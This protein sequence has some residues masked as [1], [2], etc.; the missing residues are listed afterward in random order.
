MSIN[1]KDDYDKLARILYPSIEASGNVYYGQARKLTMD[2]I[3]GKNE[4]NFE[5]HIESIRVNN[6]MKDYGFDY[7]SYFLWK[8]GPLHDSIRFNTLQNNDIY[9][10]ENFPEVDKVALINEY[11]DEDN[12][13]YLHS[14]GS[15]TDYIGVTTTIPAGSYTN[16]LYGTVFAKY[17]LHFNNN[18]QIERIYSSDYKTYNS[19]IYC[20]FED[21]CLTN[22][23]NPT[24]VCDKN[25]G[26]RHFYIDNING[27]YYLYIQICTSNSNNYYYDADL[28][29]V[30]NDG[31]RHEIKWDENFREPL[32]I[33]AVDDSI[34]V[35]LK[36]NSLSPNAHYDYK[37][38]NDWVNYTLGDTINLNAGEYVKFRGDSY[39]GNTS[40]YAQFAI[41]GSGKA[42]ISG[43]IR[44][45]CYLHNKSE[46]GAFTNF[47]RLFYTSDSYNQNIISSP[48][49]PHTKSNSNFYRQLFANCGHL[50]K[51]PI[52]LVSQ[53]YQNDCMQ[54]FDNCESLTN[55]KPINAFTLGLDSFYSTFNSCI[56]LNNLEFYYYNS[57]EDISSYFD[58]WLDNINTIGTFTTN[59]SYLET[60]IPNT[61]TYKK[62]PFINNKKFIYASNISNIY[63]D[64]GSFEYSKDNFVVSGSNSINNGRGDITSRSTIYNMLSKAPDVSFD[65]YNKDGSFNQEIWGYKCF[66]SP[67]SFRNGIYGECAS[68]ITASDTEANTTF[69][70]EFICKKDESNITGDPCTLYKTYYRTIYNDPAEASSGNKLV[71]SISSM[72]SYADYNNAK[73]F[74]N[75]TKWHR[76]IKGTYQSNVLTKPGL[77]TIEYNSPFAVVNCANVCVDS[78]LVKTNTYDHEYHVAS[79]GTGYNNNTQ[80]STA[81]ATFT[82]YDVTS[83][84]YIGTS[85]TYNNIVKSS[86]IKL[87]NDPVGSENKTV[88]SNCNEK[89]VD[90]LVDLENSHYAEITLSST[91]SASNID[92]SADTVNINGDVTIN[93]NNILPSE[94][95][96]T[97]IGSPNKKIKNIFAKNINGVLP[98]V[99][100]LDDYAVDVPVGTIGLFAFSNR[101]RNDNYTNYTE[102]SYKYINTPLT[103]KA[104]E[105]STVRLVKGDAISSGNFSYK[106]KKNNSSEYSYSGETIDLSVGDTLSF[107]NYGAYGFLTSHSDTATDHTRFEI[108]GKVDVYG[109]IHSMLWHTYENLTDLT[110]LPFDD[111]VD[112][113]AFL[114]WQC[115]INDASNLVFPATK[116]PSYVYYSMFKEST[117]VCGPIPGKVTSSHSHAYMFKQ[118]T[119]LS[120]INRLPATAASDNCYFEMFSGCTSLIVSPEILLTT[121]ESYCCVSMFFGCSSLKIGPDLYANVLRNFCFNSM[122]KNCTSLEYVKCFATQ[123]NDTYDS[124]DWLSGASNVYVLYN[125]DVT[126]GDAVWNALNLSS[127]NSTHRVPVGDC[128]NDGSGGI[129]LFSI[130]PGEHLN[131]GLYINSNGTQVES[132][133]SN[134]D[135]EKL[136]K[137]SNIYI[138]GIA[139]IG[140]NIDA[141]ITIN[142]S[143][144][145]ADTY[146]KFVD[147]CIFKLLS[148]AVSKENNSLIALAMRVE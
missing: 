109:N 55:I 142:N 136:N 76:S 22:R 31:K 139:H 124:S 5:S 27:E 138:P 19:D 85:C 6:P 13:Y 135:Y 36:S 148:G 44:S 117:V 43:D 60:N 146:I 34:S 122:F 28:D 24:D 96:Y 73:T 65:D 23:A 141:N 132:D 133:L 3:L 92:I 147:S 108:T 51:P 46:S 84:A 21:L 94:D 121:L 86:S 38:N 91:S 105:P 8:L 68:L 70:S 7:N 119:S 88:L 99:N 9:T 128:F 98:C 144:D 71:S 69:A 113:F 17:K 100:K 15:L 81:E 57:D 93:A 89:I 143:Y 49:L 87:A 47:Y 80:I 14:D 62:V 116:V 78:S 140:T 83:K 106:Y 16:K 33:T 75:S 102:E 111:K 20:T 12:F 61:W 42:D 50:V 125:K 123:F 52:I 29:S 25:I 126:S 72:T 107:F 56:N 35:K 95:D 77:R 129:S 131:C 66:N 134:A 114:F 67:V 120:V 145:H 101:L 1:N 53:H 2:E 130:K 104:I 118:C 10:F 4:L 18:E 115:N 32:T 30:I 74:D 103:F 63:N 58:Q 97:S 54:M 41:S 137:I 82:S 26:D 59:S 11:R 64:N 110:E 37:L 79:I 127:I 112:L 45:M 40:R 90:S 48:K 39:D